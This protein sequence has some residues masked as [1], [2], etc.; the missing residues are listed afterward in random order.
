VD[1][2]QV[3]KYKMTTRRNRPTFAETKAVNPD[4]GNPLYIVTT[5]MVD[6]ERPV[7]RSERE[8]SLAS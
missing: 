2:S 7:E 8:E 4:V 1:E 5:L 6:K 3:V